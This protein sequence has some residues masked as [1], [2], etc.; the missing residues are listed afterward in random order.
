MTIT[1]PWIPFDDYQ[2]HVTLA[3][4]VM[5][6]RPDLEQKRAHFAENQGLGLL[7]AIGDNDTNASDRARCAISLA[8]LSAKVLCRRYILQGVLDGGMPIPEDIRHQIEHA[9][10]LYWLVAKMANLLNLMPPLEKALA[11]AVH[12]ARAIPRLSEKK[13]ICSPWRSEKLTDAMAVRY[14]ARE[15]FAFKLWDMRFPVWMKT[16]GALDV[17]A[18]DQKTPDD[19]A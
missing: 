7:L 10:H 13:R 8:K 19:Q 1:K 6:I 4:P 16:T 5:N 14:S 9:T 3:I 17:H 12:E 11:W 2:D 15:I 18:L